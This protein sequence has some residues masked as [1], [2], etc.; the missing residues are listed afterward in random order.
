MSNEADDAAV[1]YVLPRLRASHTRRSVVGSDRQ[2]DEPRGRP[3]HKIVSQIHSTRRANP[4]HPVS[5]SL[6]AS[7]TASASLLLLRY[8][9]RLPQSRIKVDRVRTRAAAHFSMITRAA[10]FTVFVRTPWKHRGRGVASALLVW[11]TQGA[12]P[13]ECTSAACGGKAASHACMGL[14]GVR[15]QRPARHHRA[16]PTTAGRG[17]PHG[18]S[19]LPWVPQ[20]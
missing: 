9:V 2:H 17:R 7:Q 12:P 19:R 15:E 11:A 20:G 5:V 10:R 14:G 18:T 4:W 1:G 16:A 6:A 13:W 3:N 8:R